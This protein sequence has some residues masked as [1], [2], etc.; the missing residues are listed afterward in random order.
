MEENM[1][2]DWKQG[3][4]VMPATFIASD[5]YQLFHHEL[6]RKFLAQQSYGLFPRVKFD[7]NCS[8]TN[9]LLQIQE[10]YC[11]A[12]T[13]N[14]QFIQLRGNYTVGLP[15]SS[16]GE[17]YLVVKTK[18]FS[19]IEINDIPYSEVIYDLEFRQ[20]AELSNIN[21]LPIIKILK[22]GEGWRIAEYIPPCFTVDSCRM[23]IE[24]HGE[25]LKLM[26]D[27]SEH[28]RDKNYPAHIEYAFS[29]FWMEL[30]YMTK[31]E[32]PYDLVLLVKKTIMSF[33]ACEPEELN[34]DADGFLKSEY[35]HN[36]IIIALDKAQSLLRK[37][38]EIL[39]KKDVK[40]EPI[41]KPP[42]PEEYIPLI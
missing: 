28:F 37:F 36:D 20:K 15:Q 8:I 42:E 40:E 16:A 4:E 10:I 26:E 29:L 19:Q 14:G 18:G 12:I 25:I 11:D 22:E 2:I 17:F 27:I 1:R 38:L 13:R 35:D 24:K 6:N 3:M 34:G 39:T 21:G 30:K 9:N 5:N 33:L 7:I 41:P 31:N 23:L 32:I